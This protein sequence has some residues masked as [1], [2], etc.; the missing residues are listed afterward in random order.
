MIVHNVSDKH[1]NSIGAWETEP[2]DY[3]SLQPSDIGRTVIFQ[4]YGRAERGILTSWKNGI[5]FARYTLGDTAAG[6][7]PEDLSFGVRQLTSK[8]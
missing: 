7:L 4:D 2:L 5:V 1:S 3:D 6:A 8:G